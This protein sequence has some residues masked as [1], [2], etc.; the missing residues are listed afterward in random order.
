MKLKSS[1]ILK[2]LDLFYNYQLFFTQVIDGL[3]WWIFLKEVPV[4]SRCYDNNPVMN[5]GKI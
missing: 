2:S 3:G 1:K 4:E 5:F